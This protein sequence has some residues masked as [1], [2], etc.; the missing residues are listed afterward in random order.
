MIILKKF[1]SKKKIENVIVYT[2]IALLIATVFSYV[3]QAVTII[4]NGYKIFWT[5]TN[6]K[7]TNFIFKCFP[8]I[9][10]VVLIMLFSLLVCYD[11]YFNKMKKSKKTLLFFF[12]LTLLGILLLYISNNFAIGYIIAGLRVFLYLITIILFCK[13][14][15]INEETMKKIDKAIKVSIIIEFLIVFTTTITTNVFFQFGKGANRFM[16]TF[17]NGANLGYYTVACSMYIL[18]RKKFIKK[19]KISDVLYLAMLLLLSIASGSRVSIIS[20]MLIIVCFIDYIISSKK[21][22]S[23]KSIILLNL[24]CILLFYRVTYKYV[25]RLIG[26]G[27]LEYSGSYRINLFLST[28]NIKSIGEFLTLLIG[29]GIGFGTNTARLLGISNSVIV[30]GTYLTIILQY[31]I[32]GFILFVKGIIKG[33]R[34]SNTNIFIIIAVIMSYIM[35]MLSINIFEQYAFIV[36]A[37]YSLYLLFEKKYIKEIKKSNK[38]NIV[39]INNYMSDEVVK[40]RNNKNIYSQPGNNKVKGMIKSLLTTDSKVNVLSS[41][42]VNNKSFKIYKKCY[43]EVNNCNVTYCE[44]IDFPFI[45]TLS[46]IHYIYKEIERLNEIE[47]I[48]NIIFYNY[49]PESAYAA[50]FAKKRLDIPITVEYEDGY[51][52]VKEISKLKTIIFRHTEKKVSK[53]IDSA[54]LVNSMLKEKHKVP[55]VV[56]RGVVDKNFYSQCKNYKKTRNKK[57]TILYSGGLDKSRGINVL[58][59]SLKYIDEDVNLIITGKGKLDIKDDRIDFKGFV[60]YEEMKK[61][62]MQADLLVQ[63]Q[64]VNDSFSTSSFPSKLFEYI[65][66]GNYILSSK[67]SDVEDFAKDS[68]FYYNNDDPKDMANKIKE[69]YKLWMDKK[70]NSKLDKLCKNNM[71]EAIGKEIYNILK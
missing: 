65:A 20:N 27:G 33:I 59:E 3:C 46:S 10:E 44:I 25:M 22:I 6:L 21:I 4:F 5:M 14:I 43:D 26:R 2:F 54:I 28:F 50:Y 56:V 45:N 29:K 1:F 64:L 16:G 67:V 71:P 48:D 40:Q 32:I 53:Y 18:I 7:Q 39:Y 61:L 57:F 38:K 12:V 69:I 41:G 52:D 70:D 42:L 13:I 24:V 51:S 55:S 8:F 62:M 60:D 35:L 49:K 68:I 11:I 17:G 19:I 63:C 66:T 36:I 9:K 30:D 47:K 34:K 15:D 23:N 31:G 58:I 37:V